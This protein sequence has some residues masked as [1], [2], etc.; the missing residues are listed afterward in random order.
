MAVLH[1][2]LEAATAA[3]ASCGAQGF[4]AAPREVLQHMFSFLPLRERCQTVGTVCAWWRDVSLEEGGSLLL[5]L[6]LNRLPLFAQRTRSLPDFYQQRASFI[7]WLL[8]RRAGI[9]RLALTA[10]RWEDDS[11]AVILRLAV[12]E[13]VAAQLEGLRLVATDSG[14]TTSPFLSGGARLKEL[15]LDYWGRSNSLPRA[16]ADCTALTKLTVQCSGGLQHYQALASLKALQ[17]LS[18]M[19]CDWQRIPAEVLQ[20]PLTRLHLRYA[21]FADGGW[22]PGDAGRLA[23]TLQELALP[24]CQISEVPEALAQL[25]ALTS[26]C[27]DRNYM[28]HLPA[29]LARLR[30]LQQLSCEGCSALRELPPALAAALPLRSLNLLHSGVAHLPLAAGGRRLGAG[31]QHT[32]SSHS[33]SDSG[34]GDNAGSTEEQGTACSSGSGYLSQLTELRWG[35]AE[36]EAA[37]GGAAARRWVGAA[38]ALATAAGGPDL[39]PVA[40][41][42]GLRVLQLA[43]VPAGAEAQL[44]ELRERLPLLARLQVNSAVLL[45]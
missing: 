8:R 3:T 5:D 40:Q 20:L 32:R 29:S 17:D 19:D 23:S 21:D 10:E 12:A 42:T 38:G 2:T 26:L 35:V 37:G 28:R 25:S 39:S 15:H 43:H 27:L 36:W 7:A 1:D 6:N 13:I 11:Q 16:L 4:G 9:R 30:R 33:S 41:A 45:E 31:S 14:R 44:A 18:V 24:G 34:N 22:L